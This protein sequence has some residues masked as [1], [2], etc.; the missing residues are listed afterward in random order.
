MEDND[1]F[2]KAA[3]SG[4]DLRSSNPAIAQL[5]NKF[6]TAARTGDTRVL[7]QAVEAFPK[8]IDIRIFNT[9]ALHAAVIRKQPQ[10]VTVLLQA[11]ASPNVK[12]MDSV[13]SPMHE[14]AQNNDTFTLIQLIHKGGQVNLSGLYGT[15][16]KFAVDANA[17][18]TLAV[19]LTHGA[20]A[21]KFDD[22][23]HTL[24]HR[25]ALMGRAESLDL[26]LSK[27]LDINARNR[28]GQTPLMVAVQEGKVTCA[29][30]LLEHGADYRLVDDMR[31]TALDM[32]EG[33]GGNSEATV[34]ALQKLFRARISRDAA[35]AAAPFND[36][37]E[38]KVSVRR[39][40]VLKNKPGPLR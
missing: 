21:M 15:P 19:L 33:N 27:D 10:A 35:E 7:K 29:K 16:A 14:A 3:L 28:D 20:A 26:L 40:L 30:T 12:D 32:I 13:S 9:T 4:L 39:P 38:S 34:E 8:D 25:A 22:D 18:K 2:K 1:E 31:D 6:L 11:G 24:L 37:A 5:R 36:G 17:T 23:G